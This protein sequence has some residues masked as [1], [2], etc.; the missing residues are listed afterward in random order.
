MADIFSLSILSY[1]LGSLNGAQFLHHVLRGKFPKHI[2]RIGT[3]NAGM[4]NVWV[5]VGKGL[6]LIV[7]AIDF[8]KAY[9]AL[10]LGKV[11]GMEGF[12]LIFLGA[13]VILGHNWPLFFHFRGGRGF[14]SL[15]GI[16]YAFDVRIALIASLVSLP[17][18]IL[19]RLA[20]VTPFIFL[21]IGSFAFY[22]HAYLF[23][24]IILFAKRIYAEWKPLKTSRNKIKTLKNLLLYDRVTS[25]PPTLKELLS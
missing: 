1:F 18:A 24:A 13:F 15:I 25:N 5:N 12:S 17:V 6:G 19:L 20:G 11:T 23:I 3:Q 2:T 8:S 22:N 21:L 14:A 4:Q 7:F 16:F 10:T 9:L